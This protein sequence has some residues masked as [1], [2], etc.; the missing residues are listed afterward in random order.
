MN[1]ILNFKGDYKGLDS[2]TADANLKIY[3]FNSEVKFEEKHKIKFYSVFKSLRIYLMLVAVVLYFAGEKI[4]E[5]GLLLFLTLGY[6]FFEIVAE[7]YCTQ[8]LHEL[9]DSGETAVIIRAVRDGKITLIKSE[10]IVQDDL[11]ILQGGENVPADA[12]IL[13]SSNVTVDESAFGRSSSPA[14]K[15]AGT[16][17][18]HELKQSCVYKGTKVVSG[19]LIARVFATGQDVKIRPEIRTAKEIHRT[20]FESALGKMS[21]LFTYGAAI[22]LV[23]TAVAHFIMAGATKPDE[24]IT[25]LNYL[26]GISLPAVSFALCAI[27]V[28]FGTIIRLYYVKG[29]AKLSSDYG[30]VK[31]LR[32]V[33]ILNGVTVACIDIDSVIVSDSTPI[34]NE[35]SKN[36]DMLTRIAALS[37]KVDGSAAANSYEKAIYISAAFKHMNIKELHQNNLLQSYI[38]EQVDDYNKINGNLWVVNGVKLLCV[39]GAPEVILSFC[40]L[41][42]E[43]LFPIQQ[44]QSEYTKQGH[45]VLAVAFAKIDDTE[46]DEEE[47][48]TRSGVSEIPKS[49]FDVGYT[50]LGLLAFSTSIRENIPEAVKNCYRAGINVVMMSP[51]ADR[52]G[53]IETALA[54]ARKAG[55]REEGVLSGKKAELVESL[56]VSGETVAV[57]GKGSSDIKSLETAD[58]GIALS[59]HTTG[60]E[61]DSGIDTQSQFTTG[62]ACESCDLFLEKGGETAEEDAFQ[63]FVGAFTESRQIHRNINR[64]FSIVISTFAAV[65]LF[66]LLNLFIGSIYIP[67][68]VF[69]STLAVVI[70]PVLTMFYIKNEQE[71]S[72]GADTPSFN[73]EGG[74]NPRLLL[75]SAIQGASLF[76]TLLIMFLIFRSIGGNSEEFKEGAQG[77]GGDMLRSIFLT[78]F[79]SGGIATAWVNASRKKP[80]YK[81]FAESFVSGR[82]KSARNNRNGLLQTISAELFITVGLII[83]LLL[84]VYLPYFNSAFGLDSIHPLIFVLSFVTGSAS[85]VWFDLIKKRF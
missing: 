82:G 16:D 73:D 74:I 7:N 42:P 33:E 50:F 29:T 23:I 52:A 12:H 24:G 78:V 10:E 11:I 57:F 63:R 61:W 27:P 68:A 84:L 71:L 28:S 41:P 58:I 56:K 81:V 19:L 1:K 15:H 6:C 55:I 47:E 72:A 60:S 64:A 4:L 14:K 53:G 25:V 36:K 59:K 54:V 20:R 18:R 8:K 75:K 65:F 67:D 49:L 3:G 43:Q 2:Q 40:N 22:I 69:V 70:I 30:R 17:D 13:E 38:P 79:T 80:F 37:C 66:G 31:S 32:T 51:D 45:H 9:T 77:F 44:K 48:E 34:V 39:K 5:G 26:A 35:H 76:L 62:S 83:F 21:V 46:T 85:Q